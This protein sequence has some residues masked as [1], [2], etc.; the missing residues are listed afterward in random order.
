MTFQ[1]FLQTIIFFK[2]LFHHLSACKMLKHP[3]YATILIHAHA[4]ALN[5]PY[6]DVFY[7]EKCPHI[8]LCFA[9]AGPTM[10]LKRPV[11]TKMHQEK[12]NELYSIP[13]ATS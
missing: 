5:L 12:I 4:C 1:S 13:E 6:I 2:T 3:F 7:I 10:K 9:F 11:V 8:F